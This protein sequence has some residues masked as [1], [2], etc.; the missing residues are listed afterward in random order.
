MARRGINDIFVYHLDRRFRYLCD[1]TLV[2]GY[3][4]SE[5]VAAIHPE[6]SKKKKGVNWE[7]PKANKLMKNHLY[8]RLMYVCSSPLSTFFS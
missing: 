1:P 7:Q 6:K 3:I 5:N 8:S 2:D 4:S